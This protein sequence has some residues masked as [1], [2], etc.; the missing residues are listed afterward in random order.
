[1]LIFSWGLRKGVKLHAPVTHTYYGPDP[2]SVL[3]IS[4]LASCRPQVSRAHADKVVA[5]ETISV[6]VGLYAAGS[7]DATISISSAK[8]A[9]AVQLALQTG[10]Q[11]TS[12]RPV[13]TCL[14]CFVQSGILI[15]VAGEKRGHL[16][17]WTSTLFGCHGVSSS[18]SECN[19]VVNEVRSSISLSS[20]HIRSV[21]HL[22]RNGGN[23]G[24]G[25]NGDGDGD[26]DG[27]G[28][29]SD[30]VVVGDGE[31][32]TMIVN[33][34]FARA[35]D[36]KNKSADI[37]FAIVQSSWVHEDAIVSIREIYF[38]DG[39]VTIDKTGSLGVWKREKEKENDAEEEK[40]HDDRNSEQEHDVEGKSS[41]SSSSSRRKNKIRIHYKLEYLRDVTGRAGRGVTC[42]ELIETT[43]DKS[44]KKS[45]KKSMV[46]HTKERAEERTEEKKGRNREAAAKAA[47]LDNVGHSIIAIVGTRGVWGSKSKTMRTL[48]KDH[49]IVGYHV[50]N[51]ITLWALPNARTIYSILPLGSRHV[52]VASEV[53]DTEVERLTVWD[54]FTST[55]VHEYLVG[56]RPL[57]Y[58]RLTRMIPVVADNN[59][60][61]DIVV[62]T[63]HGYLLTLKVGF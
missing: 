31:G 7:F 53:N 10:V 17:A 25:G 21:R 11:T 40:Q 4:Y 46:H 29:S 63:A 19:S 1:M 16:M 55:I 56:C 23:G 12:H 57:Q 14:D 42:M 52:M 36:E 60:I 30:L 5:L 22:Q 58:G 48:L 8:R 32:R 47:G 24:N 62:G 6:G 20:D 9:T 13:V 44:E 2:D 49:T 39:F 34:L 50:E 37:H 3:P 28:T 26:G 54:T 41:S 15:I 38:N 45:E 51:G 18:F 27:T 61:S 43:R 59:R 35:N 33:V